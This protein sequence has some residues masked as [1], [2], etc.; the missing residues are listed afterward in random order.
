VTFNS[1]VNAINLQPY[2]LLL[3]CQAWDAEHQCHFGESTN[4]TDM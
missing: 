4:V 2:L 1:D 3:L